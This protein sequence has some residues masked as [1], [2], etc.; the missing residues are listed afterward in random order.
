MFIIDPDGYVIRKWQSKELNNGVL[1]GRFILPEYPKVG[2][3]IIRVE[4]QGQR[5]EKAIKV[6]LQINSSY[7]G[8]RNNISSSNENLMI[9]NWFDCRL[10]NTMDQNLKCMSGC[11]RLFSIQIS[12]LRQWYKQFILGK[13][14]QKVISGIDQT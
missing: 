6:F 13:K 12:T 7:Y 3:W 9:N 11:Q 8:T 1:S 10:R 4:A 14:L 5:N 2:F